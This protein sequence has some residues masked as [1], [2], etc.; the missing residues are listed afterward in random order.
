MLWEQAA[1][2]Y[3]LT[4]WRSRRAPPSWTSEELSGQS[5]D[6]DETSDSDGESSE[7][8]DEQERLDRILWKVRRVR[9]KW[10][11]RRA[12][13]DCKKSRDED[14]ASEPAT[15]EP[16][17]EPATVC[18]LEESSSMPDVNALATW[19]GGGWGSGPLPDYDTISRAGPV[20]GVA[21]PPP[22]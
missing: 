7:S 6:D 2:A 10:R 22:V 5:G 12:R 13:A 21:R 4:D 8:E 17:P 19:G 1:R 16:E 9:C 11:R 15:P 20:L 3:G 18:L 14:A